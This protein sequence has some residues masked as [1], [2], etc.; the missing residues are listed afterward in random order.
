MRFYFHVK[1]QT[2]RLDRYIANGTFADMRTV[3]YHIRKD[4]DTIGY[5]KGNNS[6]TDR[7]R[8]FDYSHFID[9][10]KRIMNKSWDTL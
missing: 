4:V 1:S 3:F 7:V 9:E 6:V 10:L 2:D 5:V 8:V